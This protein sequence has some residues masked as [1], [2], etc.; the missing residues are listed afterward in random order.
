MLRQAKHERLNSTALPPLVL[1]P[2]VAPGVI[3][4]FTALAARI[5]NHKDYTP[6]IDQ[7][8]RVVGSAKTIDPS[9]WKPGLGIQ[10]QAGRPTVT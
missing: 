2:A 1:P 9:S 4:R 8:L 7:D 6:A 10:K 3:A 5:K